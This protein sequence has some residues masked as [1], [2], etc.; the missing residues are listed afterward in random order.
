MATPAF[1]PQ[2]R[3]THF[4]KV[5]NEFAENQAA[6]IP[7][8]RALALIIWRESSIE[9]NGKR[10][11]D[12]NGSTVISDA[13]WTEW[14]GLQPRMK[15]LA[16]KGLA[17]KGLE[18]SG[19]GDKAQFSWNWERWTQAMREKPRQ[20]VYDPNREARD[21]A[22]EARVGQK[23]HEECHAT[24]CAKLREC[25]G[26][27]TASTPFLV[28]KIAQPVAQIAGTVEQ[29]TE[30]AW[31]STLAALYSFF[32]LIGLLFLERLLTVVRAIFPDVSDGELARAVRMAYTSGQKTEGLFLYRVPSALRLLRR[33][34]IQAPIQ[35][36]TGPASTCELLTEC[37]DK[38]RK[39]AAESSLR[40][41]GPLNDAVRDIVA[42]AGNADSGLDVEAA[43]AGIETRTLRAL[44]A[45]LSDDERAAIKAKAMDDLSCCTESVRYAGGEELKA[46]LYLG[47][48]REA[49]KLP[50]IS[51][52]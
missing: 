29:V 28:T 46:K 35:T 37:A 39:R 26:D 3:T 52:F 38:I 34:A 10:I 31:A 43:L 21:K 19:K 6:F 33:N 49:L 14:T 1:G 20:S 15:E 30:K 44:L 9:K 24:G 2:L 47:R 11:T 5:P 27:K 23:I 16:V 4:F 48:V 50:R 8:E 12:L 40:H 25:S 18:V 51:L 41:R 17:A 32:P 7:A 13:R 22:R 45:G 36:D 42:L